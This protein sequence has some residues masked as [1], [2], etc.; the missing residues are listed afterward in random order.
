MAYTKSGIYVNTFLANMLNTYPATAAGLNWTLNTWKMSLVLYA[1]T[2]GAAPLNYSI[3]TAPF[4]TT[5]EATGTAWVTTG[6]ALSAL[7]TGAADVV[8]TM[9]EGTAGSARYNFTN[10][11]SKVSTSIAAFGGFIIYADPIAAPVVKPMA[12]SIA[13]GASYTTVV[14]TLGITPSATGL[15]EIDITP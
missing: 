10:P 9:A 8:P 1:A 12:L 15:F 13:F 14:G 11:V 7:A 6:Y 4:V 2:D 3:A 5:Q